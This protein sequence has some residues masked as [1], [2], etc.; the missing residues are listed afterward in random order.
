MPNAWQRVSIRTKQTALVG[1]MIVSQLIGG[2]AA[3]FG[4]SLGLSAGA[5]KGLLTVFGTS[6]FF[7]ALALLFLQ[8]QV[9]TIIHRIIGRLDNIAQG[10]LTDRIPLHRL[11]ELGKLNDELVTMQ[12]HLKAMLAEIAEAAD[13]VRGN[14]AA[15][16][17]EMTEA[18]E[19]S[20]AQSTA[21][22]NIAA[23]VEELVV[24]V[25]EVAASAQEAV[26]GVESSRTLL[27]SASARMSES[28]EASQNVVATVHAAGE[29][30]SE[31]FKSI[32]AIGEVTKAIQEIADQTNLLALNAAIEAARAG[33][34]GRGF[35]VVADEV[36]KLAE[37]AKKH[38]DEISATVLQI[39]AETQEAVTKMEA[40]GSFVAT[41][42]AAMGNA[43]KGLDE[44]AHHGEEVIGKSRQIAQNTQQQSATGS[45]IAGQV[46]GIVSGI[47]QTS[48][49]IEV[50]SRQA[51][52]MKATAGDLRDL[53]GYFRY[54]D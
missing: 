38:S 29:T 46:E 13:R 2:A 8:N 22:S 43:Q 1:W 42:E 54:I 17:T 3:W 28:R 4:E 36:R 53:I 9:L 51:D 41:T 15:L 26:A 21:T 52:E 50:A 5:V 37:K 35:A 48:A 27:D 7:A 47:A 34:Q 25:Q 40:A 33:E 23:A 6:T 11:D 30:M 16:D 20:A 12:T 44:V 10:D 14:A 45:A 19:A 49:V 32:F 31:L 39:Q 18:H 24:S